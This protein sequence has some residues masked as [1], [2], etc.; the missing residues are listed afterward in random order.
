MRRAVERLAVELHL[1]NNTEINFVS[2]DS[3]YKMNDRHTVVTTPASSL[4]VRGSSS[5]VP[6]ALLS[7]ALGSYGPDSTNG[8]SSVARNSYA[9]LSRLT[10]DTS[11]IIVVS[12]IVVVVGIAELRLLRTKRNSVQMQIKEKMDWHETH[13][14]GVSSCRC[15]TFH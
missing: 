7:L 13:H 6:R 4:V 5:R 9:R 3:A 2:Y 10:W 11:L 8:G 15:A 14:G 1:Y 12:S